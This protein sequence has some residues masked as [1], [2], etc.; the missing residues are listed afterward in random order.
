[1]INKI[2]KNNFYGKPE[3]LSTWFNAGLMNR[4]VAELLLKNYKSSFRRL[5][6]QLAELAQP[7]SNRKKRKKIELHYLLLD[8]YILMFFGI[9]LECYLK[10]LLIKTKKINPLSSDKQLL[11]RDCLKHLDINM[12]CHAIGK[13]TKK[14]KDA[15]LRLQRAI[16]AGK[17]PVEKDRTKFDAYTAYLNSDIR[18][19][20]RMIQKAK[21]KW[22]EIRFT[23]RPRI[24]SEG[25]YF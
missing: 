3:E 1:M 21:Q 13:P 18:E 23:P 5:D 22:D 9:S 10:G 6:T 4:I 16:N 11:S 7:E 20:K 19:T 14:E 25:V 12:F 17:Y 2:N 15:I 24:N 8:K